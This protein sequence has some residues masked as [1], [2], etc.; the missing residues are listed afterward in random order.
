MREVTLGQLK[1]HWQLASLFSTLQCLGFE[2]ILMIF[3]KI[4]TIQ[5]SESGKGAK[6]CPNS[7][8]SPEVISGGRPRVKWEKNRL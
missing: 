3:D 8:I 6:N 1:T 2:K 4:M 7:V 5:I